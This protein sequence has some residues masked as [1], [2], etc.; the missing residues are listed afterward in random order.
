MTSRAPG[1][2]AT[3]P[4]ASSSA[5]RDEY[6]YDGGYT[7]VKGLCKRASPSGQGDVRAVVPCAGPRPVRLRRGPGG[8]R[9]RGA[10]GPLLRHRPAPQRRLLRQG[11]SRRDHRGLPGR[12]R[13]G[14][15]LSGRSAPGHPLRQYQAGG[16]QD[17]G[18]W[19]ASTHPRLH[20]APVP[21]PVRGPVRPPR[22]GQ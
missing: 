17:T 8:H 20:R 3:Q 7:T 10:Q 9:R 15:R 18:G 1:S 19:P 11:L 16:G 22:Q 21:L 5:C 6:G 13:V 4:S 2:S 12:A 14:V